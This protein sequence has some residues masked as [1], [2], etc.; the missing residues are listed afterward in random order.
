MDERWIHTVIFIVWLPSSFQWASVY[1]NSSRTK[2]V[3]FFLPF[4]PSTSPF[5]LTDYLITSTQN[6]LFNTYPLWYLNIHHFCQL[7][8]MIFILCYWQVRWS[9]PLRLTSSATWAVAHRKFKHRLLLPRLTSSH[10]LSWGPSTFLASATAP[11][12]TVALI[13]ITR[14]S[15]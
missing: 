7:R 13:M 1:W 9:L 3:I 8:S 10:L 12:I 6:F 2:L 5:H 11:T 4:P 15:Y 14:A